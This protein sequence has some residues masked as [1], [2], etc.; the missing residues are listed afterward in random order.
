MNTYAVEIQ[1]ST[2]HEFKNET[3]TVRVTAKGFGQASRRG[4]RR[5]VARAVEWNAQYPGA[6]TPRL[7]GHAQYRVVAV[8][9]VYGRTPAVAGVAPADRAPG[10]TFVLAKDLAAFI[11]TLNVA[12]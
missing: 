5:A 3:F 6:R 11:A 12:S 7:V 10:T 4:I 2:G 1:S 8:R 9:A